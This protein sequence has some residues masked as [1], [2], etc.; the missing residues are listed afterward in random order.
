M[1]ALRTLAPLLLALALV[2][3]AAPARAEDAA[4]KE[5]LAEA[6]NQAQ[7]LVARLE[8]KELDV[9]EAA[10]AAAKEEQHPLVTAALVKLLGA[11]LSVVRSAAIVALAARSTPE[12][13]KA[14]ALGLAARLP[15][16]AEPEQQAE[17][18]EVCG[19]LGSLAQVASI[20]ALA[21][22]VK[23]D[24][25][26]EELRARLMAIAN[27]PDAQAIETLIDLRAKAGN[28]AANEENRGAWLCR[29]ALAAAIG[30]DLGSDTDAW[31][32]WWKDNAA[33][34][35]FVAAAA[36]RN[37]KSEKQAA[38]EAKKGERKPK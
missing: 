2:A 16:L 38:R 3:R 8:A 21:D 24:T 4:A 26:Q 1:P 25:P 27:V 35:D 32:A 31:R 19:A 10:L 15:R 22:G 29:Q 30:K 37:A 13:R 11:E 7:A 28:H 23:H 14:A 20:K 9:K 34:F 5:A 18:L 17:L 12:G 6:K 33:T 36:A